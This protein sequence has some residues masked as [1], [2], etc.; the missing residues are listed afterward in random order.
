MQESG[1]ACLKA[2]VSELKRKTSFHLGALC[3]SLF[4]CHVSDGDRKQGKH[5]E[6]VRTMSALYNEESRTSFLLCSFARPMLYRDFLNR[7]EKV[8]NI[9]SYS[10]NTCDSEVTEAY[11]HAVE[12]LKRFRDIRIGIVTRYIIIPAKQH[13]STAN[14]GLNLAVA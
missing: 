8:A 9:R 11:H 12:E 14:A 2:A 7:I 6:F 13:S 4:L 5:W 1:A 10:E 3:I